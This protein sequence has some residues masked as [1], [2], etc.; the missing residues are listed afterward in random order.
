MKW[1]TNLYLGEHASCQPDL[2]EKLKAG[3]RPMNV[4]LITLPAN[5]NNLMDIVPCLGGFYRDNLYVVGVA[6]GENEARQVVM[7]IIRDVYQTT[8]GFDVKQYLHCQ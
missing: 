3:K 2:V 8:G 4:R 1:H 5:Q 7:S 6:V